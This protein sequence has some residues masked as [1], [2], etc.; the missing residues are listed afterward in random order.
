M[1]LGGQESQGVAPGAPENQNL[2]GLLLLQLCEQDPDLAGLA[3]GGG[4][5][6]QGEAPTH[7]VCSLG[8]YWNADL[9]TNWIGLS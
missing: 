2:V 3:G 7:R 5:R 6:G 8:R 4:A 9:P 1:P